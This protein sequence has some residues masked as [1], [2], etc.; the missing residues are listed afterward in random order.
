MECTQVLP[1]LE[2]R[3]A[4]FDYLDGQSVR[5]ADQ[6]YERRLRG[7]V[8]K[9]YMLETVPDGLHHPDRPSLLASDRVRVEPVESDGLYRVEDTR[10]GGTIGL[11]EW[12]NER[13]PVL[14]TLL[15]SRESDQWIR[16]AVSRSPWLDRLWLSAPTFERLWRY[17]E[18][19]VPGHRFTTLKFDHEA[20]YEVQ[21][22]EVASARTEEVD[23]DWDESEEDGEPQEEA[24]DLTLVERR[25]SAFTMADRVAT[26]RSRLDDLQR[27][28][29]PLESVVQ[30]R[31]PGSGRGGHD[32][33]YNGK[34]TNR[35]DSFFDHRQH[36]RY[37]T[38]L[39]REATDRAEQA[40]WMHAEA[41][42]ESTECG[43][44]RFR[45]APLLLRF[46]EPLSAET[47]ERWLTGVFERKRNRFRLTGR[48]FRLGPTK[49]H[50]CA[51]DRHLW[52]PLLLEVSSRHILAVLPR[53]TCGNTVHRLVTNIQRFLDPAVRAWLGDQR[54][55]DVVQQTVTR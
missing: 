45:G 10:W 40:L 30:L 22:E 42:E 32:F 12:L 3:Q 36:V 19:S 26:V 14:Y 49:A 34:V 18:T 39:Y 47:F 11:L 23:D 4:Y 53:G 28:Y 7:P 15:P 51:L 38:D 54:Y 9:T 46:S 24:D 43:G 33:Y 20:F 27:L 41:C 1:P 13:H 21:P 48:V 31:I 55:E 17:V 35:S 5:L 8:V 50:V 2:S 44:Y 16:E 6:L 29:K 37:V 25:R 52:Q